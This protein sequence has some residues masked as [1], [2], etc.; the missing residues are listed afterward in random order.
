MEETIKN[1]NS[2]S[3][4][5]GALTF[6]ATKGIIEYLEKGGQLVEYKFKKQNA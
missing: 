3:F 4:T 1:F 5:V 2:Y 6:R